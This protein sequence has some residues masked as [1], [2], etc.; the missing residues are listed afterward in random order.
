MHK[1]L[2]AMDASLLENFHIGSMNGRR[3]RIRTGVSANTSPVDKLTDYN[4]TTQ[5]YLVKF[6]GYSAQEWIH[7][8]NI[9]PILTDEYQSRKFI[10]AF[11]AKHPA[12]KPDKVFM[13]LRT[14]RERD[15]TT[16]SIELQREQIADYVAHQGYSL[17]GIGIDTGR[18]AKDMG[19]LIGLEYVLHLIDQEEDSDVPIHL[20]VWN[21][22]RFSRNTDQAIHKLNELQSK[23]VDTYFLMDGVSYNTASGRHTIRMALSTAQHHSEATSELVKR[24]LQLKKRQGKHIGGLPFGKQRDGEGRLEDDPNEMSVIKKIGTIYRQCK[25]NVSKTVAAL[26]KKKITLRGRMVSKATINT[27]CCRGYFNGV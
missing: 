27:L 25:F 18:S 22:S 5:Q 15:P 14:S 21:V 11:N 6:T 2:L 1:R 10:E 7:V 19:N 9:N 4:A 3:Y 20:I 24:I 12:T 13:Y 16:A 17:A 8:D 23:G 26:L